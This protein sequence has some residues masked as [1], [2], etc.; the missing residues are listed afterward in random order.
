ML[1]LVDERADVGQE[2]DRELVAALDELLGF[3]G[4]SHTGR[5]TSQD[6]C[7]RRQGRALREEADQLGHAE[8][9]VTADA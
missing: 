3:L 5:G 9:E 1:D 6:D 2:L 7:A 8:D 4:R